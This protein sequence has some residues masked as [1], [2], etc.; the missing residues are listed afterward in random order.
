MSDMSAL[1]RVR[2]ELSFSLTCSVPYEE[3][4][5]S[6]LEKASHQN[7]AVPTP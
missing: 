1:V 6:K 4:M 2:R 7:P 5:K 3:I